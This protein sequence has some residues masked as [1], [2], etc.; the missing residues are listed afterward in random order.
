MVRMHLKY[1]VCKPASFWC[2]NLYYYLQPKHVTMG[3]LVSID[4]VVRGNVFR[5]PHC[6]S[7]D[8]NIRVVQMKP[9]RRM[10]WAKELWGVEADIPLTHKPM[11]WSPSSCPA[12]W[13]TDYRHWGFRGILQSLQA[14]ARLVSYIIPLVPPSYPFRFNFCYPLVGRYNLSSDS[15]VD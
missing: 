10:F 13:D 14:S 9:V 7:C 12:E 4:V 11:C 5:D 1:L 6:P 15:M 3:I 8:T 2:R